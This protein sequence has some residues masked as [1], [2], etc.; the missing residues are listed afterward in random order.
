MGSSSAS[1]M[2]CDRLCSARFANGR[3]QIVYSSI[4]RACRQ[5]VLYQSAMSSDG[6]GLPGRSYAHEEGEA[7]GCLPESA[8][9]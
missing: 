2:R 4:G 8:S 3:R 9:L 5:A 7:E 6:R 1:Y